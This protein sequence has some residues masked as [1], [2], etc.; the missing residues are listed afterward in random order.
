[1]IYSWRYVR[2]LRLLELNEEEDELIWQLQTSGIY[3]SHSMYNVINFRGIMHVYVPAVWKIRVPLGAFFSLWLLSKD[4]LLIRDNLGKRRSIE[5]K[6]CLFCSE[7]ET[8]N[9][10]FFHCVVARQACETICEVVGFPIG[11]DYVFAAR[12]W[13]CNKKYSVVNMLSSAVW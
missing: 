11:L 7:D 10:L 9:H 1:M 5:E 2:L 3:S 6:T 12:C 8:I 13:L 4:R